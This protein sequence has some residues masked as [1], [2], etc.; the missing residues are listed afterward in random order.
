MAN[1]SEISAMHLLRMQ[2][3]QKILKPIL[4]NAL[5]K[6]LL[7]Q[8]RKII[9]KMQDAEFCLWIHQSRQLP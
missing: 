6:I 1:D 2:L 5:L 4:D 7:H 8:S 9:G 3:I